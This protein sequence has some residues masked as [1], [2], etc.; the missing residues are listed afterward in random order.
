M[1]LDFLTQAERQRYQRMPAAIAERD[2]RQH[3]HLR[4][5][6]RAFGATFRGATSRLGVALHLGLLRYLGY[7]PDEW[8]GQVPAELR[9]FV[10]GR[11]ITPVSQLIPHYH[12]GLAHLLARHL[13]QDDEYWRIRHDSTWR[14]EMNRYLGARPATLAAT[15]RWLQAN[16]PVSV[17]ESLLTG[18]GL[19]VADWRGN[20]MQAFPRE[21]FTWFIPYRELRPLVRP[22]TP[23]ARMLAARGLW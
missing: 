8:V 21:T 17:R 3:F 7:L 2:L 11:W 19:E 10:A 5:A 13:L 18:S 6:D 15:T 4:Q 20:Y 1:P 14:Q 23:L 22:G 9:A 16:T 12:E